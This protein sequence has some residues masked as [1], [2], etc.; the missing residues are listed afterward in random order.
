LQRGGRVLAHLTFETVG[1]GDQQIALFK[2]NGELDVESG[3]ISVGAPLKQRA[4]MRPEGFSLVQGGIVRT[5]ISPGLLTLTNS[6]G[7]TKAELVADEQGLAGLSL[8]YDQK[9]IAELASAGRF[10]LSN[11]PKRDSSN[12]VLNDWGADFRSRLITPSEDTTRGK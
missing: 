5:G 7:H 3:I 2:L 10:N 12:L 4:V 11:P 1:D 6:S 9:L 8:L